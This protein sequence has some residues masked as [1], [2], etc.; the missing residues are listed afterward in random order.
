VDEACRQVGEW[1]KNGYPELKVAVN[2]SPHQLQNK[3]LAEEIL[4]SMTRH[5]L[6]PGTLEVEITE[7]S[8]MRDTAL[9][10]AQMRDLSNGGITLAIDDFGTGYS[11]LGHLHRFPL[12]KL[13]IDRSFV[14]NIDTEIEEGA[15]TIPRAIITLAHELGLEVI[16]EGIESESQRDFLLQADCV[17]GQ[18]Y[19]YSRPLSAEDFAAYLRDGSPGSNV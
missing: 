7:T 9:A 2:V 8:L 10:I 12:H 4:Q 1:Q 11:S 14:N 13:K 18:G 6:S 15:G 16:A 19:L 3:H 5:N 17:A